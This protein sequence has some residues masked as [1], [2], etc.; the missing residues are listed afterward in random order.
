MNISKSAMIIKCDCV[1]SLNIEQ[2]K[3]ILAHGNM[4]KAVLVCKA[5]HFKC[6]ATQWY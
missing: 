4:I 2:H 3:V 5:E 6:L 1:L